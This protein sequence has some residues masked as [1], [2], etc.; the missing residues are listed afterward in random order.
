MTDLFDVI[1]KTSK[2]SNEW[3]DRTLIPN[4]KKKGDVQTYGNYRGI[5][6]L[7]H[8]IILQKRVIDRE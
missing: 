1:L 5:K 3:R 4:F 7:C 8:T 2:M 6:L